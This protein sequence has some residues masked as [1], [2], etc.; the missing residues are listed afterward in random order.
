MIGQ[1]LLEHI[2]NILQRQN[3][4]FCSING[5]F[6]EG[7]CVKLHAYTCRC[8]GKSRRQKQDNKSAVQSW[9]YYY[10]THF[11]EFRYIRLNFDMLIK[12]LRMAYFPLIR[13]IKS[14]VGR[15]TVTNIYTY[16]YHI[17]ARLSIYFIFCNS[18]LDQL[19]IYQ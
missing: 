6:I 5:D 18:S 19:K 12:L 2:V 1:F 7:G 8:R 10:V 11:S 13:K 14:K 15:L 17:L 3:E 4:I 16:I 9:I